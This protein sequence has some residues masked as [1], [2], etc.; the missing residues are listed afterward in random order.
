MIFIIALP[1]FCNRQV[2]GLLDEGCPVVFVVS[3]VAIIIDHHK[4][5][6]AISHASTV[7]LHHYNNIIV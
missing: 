1:E 3:F 6:S 7:E 5:C 4:N 2:L